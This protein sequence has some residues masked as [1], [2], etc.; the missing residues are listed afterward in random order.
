MYEGYYHD[1]SPR[2]QALAFVEWLL[3]GRSVVADNGRLHLVPVMG[4]RVPLVAVSDTLFRRESDV[5]ATSVF[6]PDTE[7]TMVY[8]G[9]SMYAERVPRWRVEVVRVPVLASAA[10]L[11]TT[12]LVGVAW[13]VHAR[14]AS[15]RGFWWLKAALLLCA[16]GLVL[17]VAGIMGVNDVEVGTLNV[18]TLA[19]FVGTM[20]LPGAAP[21]A[22]FFTIGAW[23]HGASPWLRA[24]GLAVSLSAFVASAYLASWGMI[25]F[26]TWAF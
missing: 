2:N 3:S 18:W 25:G 6:T 8:A 13:L 1:A 10:L 23:R 7:G 5:N 22:L 21:L 15:P 11:L 26:R 9:A 24:Y 20:L 19:M 16:V 17:P 14:R 12:F 4:P